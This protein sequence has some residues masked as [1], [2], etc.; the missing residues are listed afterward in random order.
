MCECFL[1][2]WFRNSASHNTFVIA[3]VL[4]LPPV[5]VEK[6]GGGKNSLGLVKKADQ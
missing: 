6:R 4:E 5:G 3:I 1:R 2:Q